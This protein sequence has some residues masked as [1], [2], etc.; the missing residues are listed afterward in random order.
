MKKGQIA[1]LDGNPSN[2]CLDNLA[3]LCLDHH[4]EYDTKTSQSKGLTPQELRSYRKELHEHVE[5]FWNQDALST[6]EGDE[7][8]GDE[9]SG[10]YVRKDRFEEAELQ[11]RL[12]PG[13]R[14]EVEGYA[15]WGTERPYGP[16]IGELE[17]ESTVESSTTVYRDETAETDYELELRFG[18]GKIEASEQS[19]PGRFGLN[20]SFE[21]E[22]QRVGSTSSAST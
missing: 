22:Y 6:G 21:G 12:L 1:H 20:V 5:E 3:F 7:I 11:V 19:A 13:K 9:I 17:F 15:L 18:E 10:R 4:D 2:N 8:S 16:N 14:V